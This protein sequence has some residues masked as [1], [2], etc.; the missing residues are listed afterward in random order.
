MRHCFVAG[1][2]RIDPKACLDEPCR[3]MLGS[4][5]VALVAE[6]RVRDESKVDARRHWPSTG[7]VPSNRG[8]LKGRRKPDVT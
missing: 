2:V 1:C 4:P 8:Q 5:A 7:A 3:D 6:H